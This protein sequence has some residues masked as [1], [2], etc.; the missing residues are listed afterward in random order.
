MALELIDKFDAWEL[1]RAQVAAILV[2][3]SANQV[4]LATDAGKPDPSL[5]KLRVYEERSNVWEVFRDDAT[6]L[7]PLVNVMVDTVEFDRGKGNVVE[8]QT[9]ESRL[10]IDCLGY[11]VSKETPGGH[12]PGDYSAALTVQRAARLVRNILMAAEN[13]YLGLRK[14]VG[15]RW[16]ESIR[17]YTPEMQGQA[18]QQIIA[19]RVSFGVKHNEVSPQISGE[20]IEQ[21]NATVK[22][23]ADGAVYLVATY[24]L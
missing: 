10:I 7:S 13:T 24:N 18:L 8:R 5:W 14:T 1:V 11:A 20:I 23:E 19:A 15:Q 4:Q 21:I 17:L 16:V 3:E 2:A 22:R 9:G 6:D 12:T